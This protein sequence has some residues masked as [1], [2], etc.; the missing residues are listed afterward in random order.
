[1]ITVPIFFHSF[2]RFSSSFLNAN[3]LNNN[4]KKKMYIKKNHK[5][6]FMLPQNDGEE[7]I[8]LEVEGHKIVG[9]PENRIKDIKKRRWLKK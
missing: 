2:P 6:R 4:N 9:R 1:S 7:P 5:F 8:I 3:T